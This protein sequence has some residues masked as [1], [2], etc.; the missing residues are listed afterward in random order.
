MTSNVGFDKN[1]IGFN[2]VSDGN[3]MVSLKNYFNSAFVNRIDNILVF[4][5]LKEE[6][7]RNIITDRINNLQTKY[8]NI[9]IN[10]KP[11]VIDEILDKSDYYEFGARRIDKI[12]SKNIESIIIDNIVMGNSEVV[13]NSINEKNITMM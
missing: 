4:N 6:D 13:I 5:R 9:S 12:I 8:N 11:R 7:I 3:V 10:I 2:K 1:S